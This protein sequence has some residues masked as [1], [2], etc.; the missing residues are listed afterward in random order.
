MNSLPWGKWSTD[1]ETDDIQRTPVETIR[2]SVKTY[3]GLH[4]YVDFRVCYLTDDHDYKPTRR[5]FSVPVDNIDELE[6]A[7]QSVRAYLEQGEATQ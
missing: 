7:F 2:V 3:S 1:F 4:R 6:N 5:G